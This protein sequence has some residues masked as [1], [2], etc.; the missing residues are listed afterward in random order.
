MK[1]NKTTK[2]LV[3]KRNVSQEKRMEALQEKRQT[4]WEDDLLRTTITALPKST[5]QKIKEVLADIERNSPIDYD[6]A[7]AA[8]DSIYLFREKWNSLFFELI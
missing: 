3:Q 2:N 4:Q 6:A 7:E 5:P 1:K 8:L